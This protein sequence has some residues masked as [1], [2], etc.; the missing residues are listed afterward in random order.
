MKSKERRKVKRKILRGL[1]V[2]PKTWTLFFMLKLSPNEN[3]PIADIVDEMSDDVLIW[4][5]GRIED[6]LKGLK[7]D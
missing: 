5:L 6:S 1:D 2:L 3:R 4:S 7:N